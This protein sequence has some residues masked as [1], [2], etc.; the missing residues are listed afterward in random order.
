LASFPEKLDGVL[1]A[2]NKAITNIF[3]ASL[4][5]AIAG[6]ILAFGIEW[7]NI[8]A[9]PAPPKGEVDEAASVKS[10]HVEGTEEVLGVRED[11][12]KPIP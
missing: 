2:Y 12:E 4:A 6:F 8:K 5:A 1:W 9:K 7:K 10:H 11:G 3:Y